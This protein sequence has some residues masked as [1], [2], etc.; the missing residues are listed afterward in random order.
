MT[1]R[2]RGHLPSTFQ[3][4]RMCEKS[5][6]FR[7]SVS[8]KVPRLSEN[9][10]KVNGQMRKDTFPS[11]HGR[12][13]LEGPERLSGPDVHFM[14]QFPGR[15]CPVCGLRAACDQNATTSVEFTETRLPSVGRKV[16]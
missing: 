8:L 16:F 9:R 3:L 13:H 12:P 14:F 6:L 5:Q 4:L 15:R 2:A 10:K 11:N 1:D 7:N